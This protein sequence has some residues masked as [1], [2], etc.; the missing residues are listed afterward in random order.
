MNKWNPF[1][2]T[3]NC[4]IIAENWRGSWF[5]QV[6]TEKSVMKQ[7]ADSVHITLCSDQSNEAVVEIVN[8][9]PVVVIRSLSHQKFS[10]QLKFKCDI[11][12][13]GFMFRKKLNSHLHVHNNRKRFKCVVC[14]CDKINPT[15]DSLK[16]HKV[17]HHRSW[18]WISNLQKTTRKTSFWVTCWNTT[19][20]NLLATTKDAR[21]A[22]VSKINW[23]GIMM[24]CIRQTRVSFAIYAK[25]FSHKS[26]LL[27]NI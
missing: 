15:L 26:F 24:K 19:S 17:Y 16:D 3:K 27:R 1:Y 23:P 2:W 21:E 10:S 18:I 7:H 9:E 6:F 20:L 4:I 12:N 13:K 25:M 5:L 22:F 14:G 8:D 11:C